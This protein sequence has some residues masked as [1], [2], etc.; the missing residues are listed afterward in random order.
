VAE[1]GTLAFKPDGS[2]KTIIIGDF[3][4][5]KYAT[6]SATNSGSK[7]ATLK[8]AGG[9]VTFGYDEIAGTDVT[10][11]VADG[12]IVIDAGDDDKTLRISGVNLNL[13][14]AGLLTIPF[15]NNP[16]KVV[17]LNKGQITVT[18]KDPFPNALKKLN[19][20]TNTATYAGI[21]AVAMGANAKEEN[22]ALVYLASPDTGTVTITGPGAPFSFGK[23][24]QLKFI[25]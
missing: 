5:G 11:N 13:T 23:S 7:N 3:I 15:V 21:G 24:A 9:T 22:A 6:I 12:D 10:L 14:S 4:T 18:T 25:K 20:G 1:G 19:D 16:S 8:P 17:L 2:L